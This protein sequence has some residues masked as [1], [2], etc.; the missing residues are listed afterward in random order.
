M[1]KNLINKAGVLC[2]VSSLSL[3]MLS[4][5]AEAGANTDKASKAAMK[6]VPGASVTEVETDIDDGEAVVEISLIKKNKKYSLTYRQS[7]N[8]LIEYEWELP[9]TSHSI[10]NQKNVSLSGIKKKARKLVKGS[11]IISARL[12]VD[13]G[14]SEYKVS[15][16]K[17]KRQ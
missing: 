1:K 4:S 8:K 10:Q 16:N 2:L 3:L 14:L 15:L 17:G 13:D 7:D 12:S 11:K 9:N 6:K 5:T